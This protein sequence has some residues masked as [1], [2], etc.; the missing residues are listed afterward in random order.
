MGDVRAVSVHRA[1]AWIVLS[2]LAALVPVSL[3]AIVYGFQL[4]AGADY[5]HPLMGRQ[6]IALPLLAG[7]ILSLAILSGYL[8]L[9]PLFLTRFVSVAARNGLQLVL[10]VFAGVLQLALF[11]L[12][13]QGLGGQWQQ[14][15]QYGAPAA[16]SVF[17]WNALWWFAHRPGVRDAN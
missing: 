1:A 11:T 3:W 8:A 17:A 4:R 13:W 5:L 7:T 14:G 15:V 10:F 16:V 6:L 2:P 9:V 12:L